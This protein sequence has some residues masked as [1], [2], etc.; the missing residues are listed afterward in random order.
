MEQNSS[1]SPSSPGTLANNAFQYCDNS[2][3]DLLLRSLSETILI[4]LYEPL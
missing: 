4:H 1:V 2:M 3:L